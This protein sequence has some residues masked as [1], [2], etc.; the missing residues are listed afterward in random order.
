MEDKILY[1]QKA[2]K[3]GNT[4]V[5]VA[6][7]CVIVAMVCVLLFIASNLPYSG[8]STIG[9]FAL[10]AFSINKL[11]NKTVFDITYA[12]YENRLVFLR[13]YGRIEWENEVFPFDEAKFFEDKIEHRG[14]VY[15]FAPDD[16]L[17][18]LLKS[19]SKN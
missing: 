12:L 1:K 6:A 10:A 16:K 11:L 18:E 13:K 17:K 14:K 3:Q 5:R 8:I 4:G 19:V 2:P 7:F 9:I 15:S